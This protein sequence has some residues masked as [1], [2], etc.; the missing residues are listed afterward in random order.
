MTKSQLSELQMPT[1]RFGLRLLVI[2]V[3][4]TVAVAQ[5]RASECVVLLH[6]LARTS[7]SM[8][9]MQEALNKAGYQVVNL[10]YPS[11]DFA[12]ARLAEIAIPPALQACAPDVTV[13]FV[14]HSLGGILVRY[15]LAQHEL[16]Q[17]G[18]VVMLAPPN[19]GSEVVDNLADVAGFSWLNGPA[20]L[21]LGTGAEDVPKQLGQPNFSL[22]IIAGTQSINL[23]LSTMLPDPDD[24]KVSVQSTKLEGMT[25]HIS[26]PVT[27]TFIMQAPDVIAQTL[28]FLANGKFN[29]SEHASVR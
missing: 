16:G 26:L 18:H 12:V 10:N 23:I 5:A 6:G 21:E 22:G 28:H 20:G 24:G 1:L 8:N 3:L 25:D 9:D 2:I 14:T 17:L 27:H 29:H 19:Q 11:R 7:N 15:Y 4:C 13:H